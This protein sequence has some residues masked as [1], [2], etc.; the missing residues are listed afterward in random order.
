MLCRA[1]CTLAEE[2]SKWTHCL[3][4]I[5]IVSV[6][7]GMFCV[8]ALHVWP[9]LMAEEEVEIGMHIF[10]D[11]HCIDYSSDATQS[12]MLFVKVII[13][14]SILGALALWSI[15]MFKLFRFRK[16][17]NLLDSNAVGGNTEA[18][19]SS[20]FLFGIIKKQSI[21][22]MWIFITSVVLIVVDIIFFKYVEGIS[23]VIDY[24]ANG[25]A[26]FLS[27]SFNSSWY[28]WCKCHRCADVLFLC[29]FDCSLCSCPRLRPKER[30][31]IQRQMEITI[32]L[33]LQTVSTNS[34]VSAL[35]IQF[36]AKSGPV[37][38]VPL[39][40]SSTHQSDNQQNNDN[41]ENINV[42]DSK[43]ENVSIVSLPIEMAGGSSQIENE[44]YSEQTQSNNLKNVPPM[45]H[46]QRSQGLDRMRTNA[47]ISESKLSEI[48]AKEQSQKRNRNRSIVEVIECP[49][50]HAKTLDSLNVAPEMLNESFERNMKHKQE[51]AKSMD[52]GSENIFRG[53]H[54]ASLCD[55]G[56][57][58]TSLDSDYST[59]L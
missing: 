30:S 6:W 50:C 10:P 5:V 58:S 28:K 44:Q 46:R 38:A 3:F 56:S 23:L 43:K 33:E 14:L 49:H 31:D 36:N 47:T 48:N 29:L 13:G 32:D 7:V 52:F 54:S 15:F 17:I 25:I 41:T 53:Q 2:L 21:I 37:N 51:K 39:Q 9:T 24:T 12:V 19:D 16:S 1:V 55:G 57:S 42:S 11:G 8:C 4:R 26:I 22:M 59:R 40:I 18:S 27:F 35:S 34:A 20:D 45:T